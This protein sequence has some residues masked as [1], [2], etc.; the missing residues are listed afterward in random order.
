MRT[1][2]AIDEDV[3]DQARD[4]AAR[5]RTPFRR[6]INE[7][8]RAGLHAVAAPTQPRKYRTPARALGLKT[9]RNLDNISELLA[10]V[11]GGDHR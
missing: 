7:A 8:L 5:L 6:V 2:L 1:T 4:L 11:E 10:Q 9:G 3:L